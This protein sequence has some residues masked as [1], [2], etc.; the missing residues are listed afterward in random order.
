MRNG[1]P[2]KSGRWDSN[3]RQQ[4]WQRCALPTE[5][6]P[7]LYYATGLPIYRHYPGE[8]RALPFDLGRLYG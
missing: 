7:H 8:A 5:L 6:R 3:P 2:V 1:K 4:R